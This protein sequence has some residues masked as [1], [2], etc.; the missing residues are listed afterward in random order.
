[1]SIY[2]NKII[3]NSA[4]FVCLLLCLLFMGCDNS[5]K[6]DVLQPKNKSAQND[7]TARITTKHTSSQDDKNL[8]TTNNSAISTITNFHNVMIDR[9]NNFSNLLAAQSWLFESS[10]GTNHASFSKWNDL[11]EQLEPDEQIELSKKAMRETLNMMAAYMCLSNALH[12]TTDERKKSEILLLLAEFSDRTGNKKIERDFLLKIIKRCESGIAPELIS[13]AYYELAWNYAAQGEHAFA[14]QCFLDAADNADFPES[15][16]YYKMKIA[17]LYLNADPEKSKNLLEDFLERYPNSKY[18]EQAEKDLRYCLENLQDKNR[19]FSR[20]LRAKDEVT[21]VNYAKEY[22][23]KYPG[24]KKAAEAEKLLDMILE[25][26]A[27]KQK[28]NNS[29]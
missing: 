23:N 13:S 20:I 6:C 26:N 7:N 27:D 5:R 9:I 15:T 2:L 16:Q 1:M 11:I 18:K 8:V 24:S 21:M 29:K 25:A 10:N 4:I 28:N 19:D 17:Q 22:I 3:V 14:E 12:G